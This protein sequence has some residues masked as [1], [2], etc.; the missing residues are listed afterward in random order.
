MR[1]GNFQC[2]RV[3]HIAAIG[4]GECFENLWEGGVFAITDTVRSMK[5]AGRA[6]KK[7]AGRAMNL[8]RNNRATS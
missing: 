7:T 3:K 2:S 4:Q 8:T 1:G 5:T 6:M